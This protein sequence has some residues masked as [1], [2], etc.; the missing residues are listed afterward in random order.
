M[1]SIDRFLEVVHRENAS[2][3]HMSVGLPPKMRLHGDL[4]N[5]VDN[6]TTEQ[7][8]D[9]LLL[10]V[11]SRTQRDRFE[12][13]GDLDFV[14][15]MEDESARF[16]V[17]YFMHQHGIGGVFR[18]IPDRI[19]TLE[20]L[21]VPVILR[22]FAEM[23]SGLVLVT[24]PTGCGKSTTLASVIDYVNENF[25]KHIITL[26]DPIEYV[27]RS[28]KSVINQRQVGSETDSFQAGLLAAIHQDPEVL[29]VGEMR[30]YETIRLVVSAAETGILVFA[31]LHTNSAA[32][33]LDRII[34]VFP[35]GQ[36]AQIRAML[37]ESLMGVVSQIL[38]KTAD[39]AGRVPA[40]E[41]LV[42]TP[43][44][45]NL[46][47]EGKIAEIYSIM[48]SGKAQGMFTMD[49]TLW[50]LLKMGLI[51]ADDAY[52]ACVDKKRFEPAMKKA[53]RYREGMSGSTKP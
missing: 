2:D 31:T 44:V 32:K 49:D 6:P 40:N 36:Q 4:I 12:S 15:D 13:T 30:D 43:A 47:R 17:N 22:K 45:S 11:L 35:S 20:E 5:I 48:Q 10:G 14:Y 24:G 18:L 52:A 29:M 46:V 8:G 42:G 37:S 41:V 16:R 3:L 26:E 21:R 38:L 25:R 23:H 1:G 33:T 9:S 53:Q 27:H 19:K 7:D 28:K 39:E 51:K 34:D 50:N